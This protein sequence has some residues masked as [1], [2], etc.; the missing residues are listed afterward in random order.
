MT[1]NRPTP[2]H[3]RYGRYV[4]VYEA[5]DGAHTDPITLDYESCSTVT[6]K[7]L[8]ARGELRTTL[9]VTRELNI[10]E[11]AG[12]IWDIPDTILVKFDGGSAVTREATRLTAELWETITT[13]FCE[14]EARWRARQDGITDETYREMLRRIEI[15]AA[16]WERRSQPK[17]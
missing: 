13:K 8:A 2:T 5:T 9:Y 14:F 4:P 16:V 1:A 17:F 11:A 7:D 3:E 6:T 10:V 15:V 12:P